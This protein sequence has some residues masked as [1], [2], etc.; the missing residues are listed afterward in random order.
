MLPFEE[1]RIRVQVQGTTVMAVYGVQENTL[2]LVSA[3]L[4]DAQ[5][6]PMPV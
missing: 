4:S 1:T 2:T 3:N 5:A 6:P